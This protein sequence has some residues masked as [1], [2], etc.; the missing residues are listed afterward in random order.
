[1]YMCD[2]K[3]DN[4]L[5]EDVE[6]LL[7]WLI[8]ALSPITKEDPAALAKYVLALVKKDKPTQLLKAS[9]V[10]Q[11][12]IFL[13]S[14]TKRFVE[15]LFEVLENKSY[16][17]RPIKTKQN[18]SH[19]SGKQGARPRPSRSKLKQNQVQL[20]CSKQGENK[21]RPP[22]FLASVPAMPSVKQVSD[23]SVHKRKI[24]SETKME[25]DVHDVVKKVQL[26]GEDPAR[27]RN[28]SI[29]TKSV[30]LSDH[31]DDWLDYIE[32]PESFEQMLEEDTDELL[33]YR[34]KGRGCL[35]PRRVPRVPLKAM[36]QRMRLQDESFGSGR[37]SSGR[38]RARML[39]NRA[40]LMKP[41]GLHKKRDK[42]EACDKNEEVKSKPSFTMLFDRKESLHNRHWL[43]E[44]FPSLGS[45]ND[46]ACQGNKEMFNDTCQNDESKLSRIKK[47]LEDEDMDSNIVARH[48]L[49][50][51]AIPVETEVVRPEKEK[52]EKFDFSKANQK[53]LEE[54][55]IIKQSGPKILSLTRHNLEK[56]MRESDSESCSSQENIHLP[57]NTPQ[58]NVENLPVYE[59]YAVTLDD[60]RK[61]KASKVPSKVKG[62]LANLLEAMDSYCE[63][64]ETYFDRISKKG[65]ESRD[66]NLIPN[67]QQSNNHLVSVTKKNPETKNGSHTNALPNAQFD[68][69]TAGSF[70]NVSVVS[71]LSSLDLP[72]END[73]Q[74]D[75]TKDLNDDNKMEFS[76]TENKFDVTHIDNNHFNNTEI[77]ESEIEI[78]NYEN[79][80][81]DDIN[82]TG[83]VRSSTSGEIQSAA[84]EAGLT[85]KD[86]KGEIEKDISVLPEKS[87]FYGIGSIGQI[88]EIDLK[89]AIP[90]TTHESEEGFKKVVYKQSKKKSSGGV[91]K[92][93]N[94]VSNDQ[95]VWR[96]YGSNA[97]Q[98]DGL[99]KN[100]DISELH[101]MV[102][103]FGTVVD[104]QIRHLSSGTS[105]RFRL[106]NKDACEY[107]VQCLDETDCLFPGIL[108]IV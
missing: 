25:V 93:F 91:K 86:I 44:D 32:V 43:K 66:V 10:E 64:P 28:P 74:N 102:A 11:L 41:H 60:I 56:F 90:S 53:L 63:D 78:D 36:I 12:D 71:D 48:C 26:S 69:N 104:F 99:P 51:Q 50:P 19:F 35:E 81:M 3:K 79:C 24:T 68:E 37:Q 103:G 21:Q 20:P 77:F 29:Q 4:M 72:S 94:G 95:T 46:S 73:C 22:R 15:R 70:S 65:K 89:S 108:I 42:V 16:L 106:H 100:C 62:H 18:L 88:D 54:F 52:K 107:A 101:G 17:V 98:V 34:K 58:E 13:Q 59:R 49:E 1:M 96:I 23:S 87:E 47:T 5:I 45:E 105:V 9:C 76:D 84:L 2:R 6:Q 14:E 33:C 82:G 57:T 92:S 7:E 83:D 40:K 31:G 61:S 30:E 97:I 38:G 67:V 85:V 39:Q 55:P 80:D 75:D 27:S 8:A